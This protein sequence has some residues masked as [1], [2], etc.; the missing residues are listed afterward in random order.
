MFFKI[1]RVF[2][3][4][5]AVMLAGMT[6]KLLDD[7][8]DHT[9]DSISENPSLIDVLG[10]GSVVYTLVFGVIACSINL[11]LAAPLMLSAYAV[12][13]LKDPSDM[14][15]LGFSAWVESMI[16]VVITWNIFGWRTTLASILIMTTVEF[17]D[18]IIDY[19]RDSAVHS[20]N[21]VYSIGKGQL[22]LISLALFIA[23]YIVD[24]RMTIVVAICTPTIA[25]A[26]DFISRSH[27]GEPYVP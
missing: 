14:L 22:I 16:I 7:F 11:K 19:S 6:I 1:S 18:D 10:P 21:F 2:S 8:L 15:P 25:I 3:D 9:I 23:S 27:R 26:A 24:R 4:I 5:L 20:G 12:G 17:V 13:M